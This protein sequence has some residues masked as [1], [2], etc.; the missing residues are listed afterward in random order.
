MI[1]TCPSCVAQ[2]LLP[3]ESIGEKGR[4]VKCTSCGYTW[5]QAADGDVLSEK[6]VFTLP[7][8]DE[9]MPIRASR[10]RMTPVVSDTSPLP[11]MLGIGSGLAAVALIV[12]L[13]VAVIFRQAVVAYAPSSALLFEKVGVP[14]KPPGMGLAFSDVKT[15]ITQIPG[16]KDVLS[17]NG[18]LANNTK[19]DVP[20][21]RLIIRLNSENGWLKDW[22]VNLYGNALTAG[23]TTD[24]NYDLKDIPENGH[25]VTLLFAD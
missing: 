5:L 16:R 11:A 18:K 2:Y 4:R 6:A 24:F 1:V 8:Y 10:P 25:S 15:Q 22:P 20:L 12:T 14:V 19:S 21:A 23:K 17:V 3:D 13:G 7:E 9:N